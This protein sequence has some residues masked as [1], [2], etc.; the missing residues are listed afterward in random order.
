MNEGLADF[1]AAS[2]SDDPVIGNYVGV[3]GLGLRDLTVARTCPNYLLDEVHA[4]GEIIGSALWTLR[5]M[6]GAE[7]TEAIA[8]RAL[9]QF[10]PATNHNSAVQLMLAAAA[11]IG[12]EVEAEANEA[13]DLHGLLNCE[14]ALQWQ[15]YS[16][17]LTGLPHLVEGTQTTGVIGFANGAPAYKQFFV[18]NTDNAAGVEL[19]W[20]L[21]SGGQGGIPGF[22]G[23]GTPSPLSLLIKSGAKVDV[24]RNR[25]VEF[26]YDY[27]STPEL[28]NNRQTVV[29][30]ADCF[31]DGNRLYT[32]FTNNARDQVSISAM[33]ISSLESLPDTPTVVRCDTSAPIEDGGLPGTDGGVD[34]GDATPA[35]DAGPADVSV[36][37]TPDAGG[38]V[39]ADAGGPV[40][41]DA[42]VPVQADAGVP[43]PSDAG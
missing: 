21:A 4:Q 32:L 22:G 33:A 5:E 34:D 6:I 42:D 10:T 36:S 28:V 11:E 37:D 23:G 25:F 14:R 20:T 17:S 13:F 29:I 12:P 30:A 1:F 24:I 3:M 43:E 39:E 7:I 19:S 41:A 15:P 2:I 16:A 9:E 38:P 8:Y 40:E 26:D 18:E 35:L 27:S 31:E